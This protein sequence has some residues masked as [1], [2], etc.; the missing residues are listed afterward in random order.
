[1]TPSSRQEEPDHEVVIVGAGF[2]GIGA[3]IALLKAGVDDILVIEKWHGVGGTWLANT[4]PGVAVD[5]PSFI[6]S[7]SYEQRSHWSRLFAP[8]NELREYAEELVDKHS[9]RSRLR[10]NTPLVTSRFDE[11]QHLWRLTTATGEEITARFVISAV[12]GLEQPKLPDIEGVDTFAGK[13]MHTATWDHDY[14]LRGK[15]VAVIGT[16]ATALQLIPAIAD[17]VGTLSVFQR[18]P[19][20]VLPKPDSDV[21]PATRLL[22]GHGAVRWALRAFGS[23]GVEAFLGGAVLAPERAAPIR[24]GVETA[25]KAWMRSQVTDPE[26]RNK[27][28]PD[29]ALGCKRPSMSNSYLRTF[30]R[31][32]VELVTDAIERVTPT[33][34]V[35]ADGRH[36]PVDVLICATGFKI[37]EKGATPPYPVLGLDGVDLADFWQANRYQAYQGVSVPGYPNLFFIM[38]PYG[39]SP[40]S[41]FWM[42]EATAFHAARVIAETRKRGNTACEIRREPHDRYWQRALKRAGRT[43]LFTSQCATSNTYYINAHGDAAVVRPSLYPEMYWQNRHFPLDDYKYTAFAGGLG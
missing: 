29:Y 31:P 21:G 36:H 4:Y 15:R 2:G 18:T 17:D 30:N 25:L 35:T 27:L 24:R 37:M 10:L 34:V 39:F 26:L 33:G 14:D 28:T 23:L 5:I 20:W 11:E 1:M 38:G 43:L 6:Y 12:G 16:G 13:L 22:L 7:F 32:H 40:G 3:A 19:I 8:G 9:L 41:Y 42:V